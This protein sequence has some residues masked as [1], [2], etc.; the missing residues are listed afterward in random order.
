MNS[1]SCLP[2]AARNCSHQALRAAAPAGIGRRPISLRNST[3]FFSDSCRGL[4]MQPKWASR[5]VI[6]WRKT[7]TRSSRPHDRVAGLAGND[8]V[9]SGHGPVAGRSGQH[10]VARLGIDEHVLDP[11][12]TGEILHR[13]IDA[14]AQGLVELDLLLQPGER[15]HPQGRTPPHVVL[16]GCLA[17]YWFSGRPGLPCGL[18]SSRDAARP[19]DRPKRRWG[20]R[21]G[22]RCRRCPPRSWWQRCW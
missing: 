10:Q 1:M 15:D 20:N 12:Q 18:L 4:I 5:P 3:A 9:L 11:P 22:C 8:A 19:W 6:I 13:F 17:D 14:L 21:R 16:P 2:T 7:T